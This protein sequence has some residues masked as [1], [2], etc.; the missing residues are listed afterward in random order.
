MQTYLSPLAEFHAT[1]RTRHERGKGP[2]RGA[3]K[4]QGAKPRNKAP[5][6]IAF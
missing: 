6:R 1:L 4:T 3:L 2:A 5:K